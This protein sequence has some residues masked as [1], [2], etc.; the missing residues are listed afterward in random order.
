MTKDFIYD[1]QY[2]INQYKYKDTTFDNY[3]SEYLHPNT[4]ILKILNDR[5]EDMYR[6]LW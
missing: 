1:G 3:H 2:F 5:L 4:S 6:A